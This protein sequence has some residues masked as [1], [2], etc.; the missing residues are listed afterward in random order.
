MLQPHAAMTLQEQVQST[1]AKRTTTI[2]QGIQVSTQENSTALTVV[3]IS[4]HKLTLLT[5]SLAYIL[6]IST[7]ITKYIDRFILLTSCRASKGLIR[8]SLVSNIKGQVLLCSHLDSIFAPPSSSSSV[9]PERLQMHGPNKRPRKQNE[10][11]PLHILGFDND[12]GKPK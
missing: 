4:V 10:I 6:L 7:Y 9:S 1:E 11:I 3:H 2:G 12:G 8:H 5:A